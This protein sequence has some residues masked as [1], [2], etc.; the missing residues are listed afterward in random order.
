MAAKRRLLDRVRSGVY[1]VRL[2]SLHFPVDRLT[3]GEGEAY[4]RP[5]WFICSFLLRVLHG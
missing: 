5:S 4:W 2:S 3:L 1:E